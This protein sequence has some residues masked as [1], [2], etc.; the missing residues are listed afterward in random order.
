[1]AESDMR[2]EIIAR[3][4]SGKPASSVDVLRLLQENE[5]LESENARLRYRITELEVDVLQKHVI[6]GKVVDESHYQKVR[7]AK[8]EEAL[9]PFAKVSDII[10]ARVISNTGIPV[11]Y[12]DKTVWFAVQ[13]FRRAAEARAALQEKDSPEEEDAI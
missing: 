10:P 12:G 7:I 8:L 13:D 9:R 3:L 2:A 5:N 1:M 11:C 6:A 4:D